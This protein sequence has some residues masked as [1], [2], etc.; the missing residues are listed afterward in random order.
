MHAS[1]E[2]SWLVIRVP[3]FESVGLV[4]LGLGRRAHGSWIGMWELGWKTQALGRALGI[5]LQELGSQPRSRTEL[6]Q[7]RTEILPSLEFNLLSNA[8][9][10]FV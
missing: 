9:R 7:G 1:M 4:G 5:A 10:A 8:K 6:N 2:I 3:V